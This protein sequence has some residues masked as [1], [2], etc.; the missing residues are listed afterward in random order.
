MNNGTKVS[1]YFEYP[2][3]VS[4]SLLIS[5][6]GDAKIIFGEEALSIIRC[7]PVKVPTLPSD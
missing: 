6:F 7:I 3:F 4:T 5:I 2:N 1:I